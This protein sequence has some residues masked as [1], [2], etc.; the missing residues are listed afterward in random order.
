MSSLSNQLIERLKD[1]RDTT[2]YYGLIMGAALVLIELVQFWQ[3]N[4]IS[5][6]TGFIIFTFKVV[7]LFIVAT[8][9]VKKIKYEFY[10]TGM[11]YG[12]AFSIVFRLFLYASLI[13][14]I[15]YFILTRWLATDYLSEVLAN[16]VETIRSYIDDAALSSSQA[17][18]IENF[19][20]E[21]EERPVPTPLAAMWSI[22]W[23][24][25]VWGVI[26]GSILSIFVR[27]KD[28]TPFAQQEDEDNSN[29]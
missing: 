17:D 23:S 19:I 7:T 6:F 22:M 28:I 11:S 20:E 25:L 1:L 26:V 29:N 2:R 27:D 18:Y 13:V 9:L 21:I 16:S 10:K 5:V 14:G 4:N 15:F 8:Y 24:Y 12:Q 3:H